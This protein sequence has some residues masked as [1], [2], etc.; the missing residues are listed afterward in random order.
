MDNKAGSNCVFGAQMEHV[1]G[2]YRFSHGYFAL[3]LLLTTLAYQPIILLLFGFSFIAPNENLCDLVP[4]FDLSKNS[5]N[6]ANFTRMRSGTTAYQRNL[7]ERASIMKRQQNVLF[8]IICAVRVRKKLPLLLRS[9]ECTLLIASHLISARYFNSRFDVD[10][11]IINRAPLSENRTMIGFL[12]PSAAPPL[13]IRT[14][15]SIIIWIYF[16]TKEAFITNCR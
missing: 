10:H 16:K 14:L 8:V 13:S 9:I 11:R 3:L 7:F 2:R 12:R 1:I 5:H 15:I 6:R 4:I